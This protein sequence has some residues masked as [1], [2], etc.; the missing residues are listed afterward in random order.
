M[1]L[2]PTQFYKAMAPRLTVLVT[3]VDREGS[4]NAAPFSFVSPVSMD[5]PLVMVSSGHGKDTLKNVR[6]TREFVLNI[7][8]EEILNEICKC[9]GKFP[10]GINELDEAGLTAEDSATVKP[11]R[12]KECIAWFECGLE[13]EHEAG[14]HVMLIGRVL[15]AEV[16]DGLVKDGN[17]DVGKAKAI[18]HIGGTEFAVPERV[19][20]AE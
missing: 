7:P 8:T 12:V 13:A 6:D 14:D 18:Q 5:P 2:N 1:D 9:G 4:I 10:H 20:N 15:K 11:P 3:T 17:L 16:K 19:V